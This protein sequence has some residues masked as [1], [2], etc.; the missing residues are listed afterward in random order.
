MASASEILAGSL[1]DHNRAIVVGT[2]T[3]GKGSVQSVAPIDDSSLIKITTTC[4]TM[5]VLM[6]ANGII[7]DVYVDIINFLL[8]KND[9]PFANMKKL[10]IILKIKANR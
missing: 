9:N 7:P 2:E 6:Q 3:F 1:Q 8:E 10:L 4:I 5:M